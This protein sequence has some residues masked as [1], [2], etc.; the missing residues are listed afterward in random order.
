[1][2]GLVIFLIIILFHIDLEKLIR[3]LSLIR[4]EYFLLSALI[5]PVIIAIR[6]VRWQRILL[7]FNIHRSV[8]DCFN[9]IFVEMVAISVVSAAGT[10]IK[11]FYL[12]RDGHRLL[13]AT[14]AVVTDK[15]FDYVLPL[16]FGLFS[17]LAF[18]IHLDPNIGLIVLLCVTGL[19]YKPMQMMNAR[20]LPRL[21]PKSLKKKMSEK[22]WCFEESHLQIIRALDFRAYILSVMG[23]LLYFLSVHMLN[24]GLGINLSYSQIILIMS[25]TSLIAA[26]PISFLGIGTRDVALITVFNWFGRSP[27]QAV[28]L[29]IALLL[30]RLAVMLMGSV[31]WYLDPP[32]LAAAKEVP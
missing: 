29:S 27:E 9:Y 10:L 22:N 12:R 24:L 18:I 21:I 3:I 30:L 2:L 5:V 26:I 14:L 8:W 7:V 6:S 25:I 13:K 11:V 32:P 4:F 16:L 1:M 15:V 23:F 28:S 31:F 17:S 19:S 20:I